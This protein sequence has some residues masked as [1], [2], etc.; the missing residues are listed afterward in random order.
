MVKN[1]DRSRDLPQ[2]LWFLFVEWPLP[3]ESR[4]VTESTPEPR[5]S[6]RK[7]LKQTIRKSLIDPSVEYSTQFV[8]KQ[9]WNDDVFDSKFNFPK[10][11]NHWTSAWVC[12]ET[13]KATAL[14][15]K[16]AVFLMFILLWCEVFRE[17]SSV[18]LP[19]HAY[20]RTFQSKSYFHSCAFTIL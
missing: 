15:S 19:E 6:L 4:K 12:F 3:G 5:R 13:F 9:K 11:C 20:F 10:L 17:L 16:N 14:C 7:C 18:C 1:I 8:H 2:V